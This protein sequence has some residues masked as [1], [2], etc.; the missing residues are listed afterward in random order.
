MR[1]LIFCGLKDDNARI[2]TQILLYI[3]IKACLLLKKIEVVLMT[4]I[5]TVNKASKLQQRPTKQFM[6][7]VVKNCQIS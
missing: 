4:S 7:F 6:E 5:F 1:K 2:R 3:R